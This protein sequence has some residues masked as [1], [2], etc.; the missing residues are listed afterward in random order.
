MPAAPAP[1]IACQKAW[2]RTASSKLAALLSGVR[3]QED[4]AARRLQVFWRSRRKAAHAGV[5]SA[6]CVPAWPPPIPQPI[7]GRLG[8]PLWLAPLEQQQHDGIVHRWSADKGRGF[9]RN[10]EILRLTGYDVR[11]A[12]AQLAPSD[13]VLGAR[14]QFQVEFDGALRPRVKGVASGGLSVDSCLQLEHSGIVCD[15][16]ET[17]GRGFIHNEALHRLLGKDVL[18]RAVQVP[19]AQVGQSVCF[20]LEL[21]AEGRPRV[22][23][24]LE[25][26]AK[27]RQA[28]LFTTQTLLNSRHTG[29]LAR[30]VPDSEQAPKFVVRNA[31]VRRLC[32]HDAMVEAEEELWNCSL[33]DFVGFRVRLSADGAPLAVEIAGITAASPALH[34]GLEEQTLLRGTVC[35]RNEASNFGFLRCPQVQDLC[36]KDVFFC[37]RDFPDWLLGKSV[38]F[39]LVWDDIGRP[40]AAP[41]EG[42]PSCDQALQ[43]EPSNTPLRDQV[44]VALGPEFG[45]L[46]LGIRCGWLPEVFYIREDF[47]RPEELLAGPGG[48]RWGSA[49][50]A[51]G[52]QGG[53]L[54]RRPRTWEDP[55]KAVRT[56]AEISFPVPAR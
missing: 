48:A 31:A 51:Q 13:L 6:I 45:P 49:P 22:K 52:R 12:G 20:Q 28:P 35:E 17:R 46:G 47:Q 30:R 43:A 8:R 3:R 32:G 55:P 23:D 38:A 5:V 24:A 53:S 21:D 7:S 2:R 39:R 4:A 14:I 33:G 41:E 40:R 11:F 56:A 36:G 54:S 26:T 10:D 15:V 25:G 16:D 44:E 18:F 50:G 42:E 27:K 29:V 9:I 19:G 34:P 37:P 1:P